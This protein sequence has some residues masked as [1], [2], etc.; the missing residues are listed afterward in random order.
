MVD[1]KSSHG[2]YCGPAVKPIALN[3]VQQIQSDPLAMLP[4]QSGIGGI[5]P[6]DDAAE[7]IL[8]GCGNVQVCTAAMHYGYR[9][10]EDMA[11]GLCNWMT[12]ARASKPSKTSAASHCRTS[13]SG[14]SLN[15]NYRVV[16]HI[17]A[18]KCIGC[19]LCYTACWDGAHQCIHLD[20]ATGGPSD[21]HTG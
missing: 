21:R 5:A 19:Q 6:G 13:P 11:D 17:H 1:G 9:I 2:G 18:D 12:R 20:R 7:F 8:L 10:V 4:A 3:M 14:S 15:L 16:A